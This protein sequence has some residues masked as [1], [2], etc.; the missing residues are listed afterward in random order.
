MIYANVPVSLF[1][2]LADPYNPAGL[3]PGGKPRRPIRFGWLRLL[4]PRRPAP[5]AAPQAEPAQCYCAASGR[6]VS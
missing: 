6:P 5:E 3:F 2:A 1:L 4:R